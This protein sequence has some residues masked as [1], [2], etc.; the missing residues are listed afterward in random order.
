[1]TFDLI[2]GRTQE[3]RLEWD[4]LVAKAVDQNAIGTKPF[5]LLCNSVN[6]FVLLLLRLQR[7]YMCSYYIMQF[8]RN[9]YLILYVPY[10]ERINEELINN[11]VPY[12]TNAAFMLAHDLYSIFALRLLR[13]CGC[14]P[15]GDGVIEVAMLLYGAPAWWGSV[16]DSAHLTKVLARMRRPTL[17]LVDFFNGLSFL[18][19]C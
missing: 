15:F 10:L 7:S 14:S 5:I 11:T 9:L 18:L 12:L 3:Q 19:F 6:E 16:G 13:V 2:H 4:R 17:G 1:M 8:F